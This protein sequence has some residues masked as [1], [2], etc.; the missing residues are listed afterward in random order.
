MTSS[1]KKNPA[2]GRG[3]SALLSDNPSTVG[4]T[5][6]VSI[7]KIEPN[8][9]NPRTDFDAEALEELAASIKELGIIQPLTLRKINADKYQ[10]ISGERRFRAAQLA[11]LKEVPAYVRVAN[12]QSMLE[13]ALVEN[14]QREN[15]NAIEIGLSYQRLL[16]ECKMTQTELGQKIA[17][18]RSD[19]TNHLRLLKL[20]AKIQANVRDG[21]LTMGHARAL[22]S[23]GDEK[24]QLEALNAILEQGL[25]VREVEQWGNKKSASNK[26]P[27]ANKTNSPLEQQLKVQLGLGVKL[28]EDSKGKGKLIISFKSSVQRDALIA[29]LNAG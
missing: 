17:K 8:P 2:L 27:L 20:P 14:I 6:L 29:K 1:N 22:L 18:S 16:D 10:I 12:D 24:Q 7:A 9:F 13:M 5:S 4:G 21:K 19:I 26:A 11:G 25:S 23:I 28:Q 15:L 3:L